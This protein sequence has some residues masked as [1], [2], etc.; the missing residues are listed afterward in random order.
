MIRELV[1]LEMLRRWSAQASTLEE[2]RTGDFILEEPED[3]ERVRTS[4]RLDKWREI[5]AKGDAEDFRQNLVWAGLSE[6]EALRLLGRVKLREAAPLPTW[7]E[8]LPRLLD[9]I[10]SGNK[11]SVSEFTLREPFVHLFL[12]L[13]QAL[14]ERIAKDWDTSRWNYSVCED[15]SNGLL[16]RIVPPFSYS[17]YSWFK[18]FRT[19]KKPYIQEAKI[20]SSNE[21]TSLIYDAYIEWLRSGHLIR[22]L[23]KHPVLARLLVIVTE[24]WE[25]FISEFINHLETDLPTLVALFF[26]CR[27]PGQVVKLEMNISE[28]HNRGR[29]VVI[30][31]FSSGDRLVYK[32]RD[33]TIDQRWNELTSWMK[34][35]NAPYDL[36][37]AKVWGAEGYGWVEYVDSV[38]CHNEGEVRAF[39]HR[40]GALLSLFHVLGGTDF[41]QENIV[42]HSCYPIPIDLETLL[43]PK[44]DLSSDSEAHPAL[45]EAQ[46][47][48]SR[49]VLASGYLP[50][51]NEFRGNTWASGG[52]SQLES[53]ATTVAG[54]EYVNTD[55]MCL[56]RVPLPPPS[57]KHLPHLEGVLVNSGD[58]SFE[59]ESG[60]RQTCQ[61]LMAHR[62]ILIRE[63]LPTFANTV[64]RIVRQETRLYQLLHK[65]ALQPAMLADGI[66]FSLEFE[67]LSRLHDRL[68]TATLAQVRAE[69]H[70][71][72]HLD[73][74]SFRMYAN[75][76]IVTEA[77]GGGF[78]LARDGKAVLSPVEHALTRLKALDEA[79]IEQQ[80]ELIRFAL[81]K[82]RQKVSKAARWSEPSLST[83]SS[84]AAITRA[85]ELGEWI[86][87]RAIMRADGAAWLGAVA[88]GIEERIK[89]MPIGFDLYSGA[90]GIAIFLGALY[91]ITGRELFRDF[92]LKAFVPLRYDL[93]RDAR[94]RS[95]ARTIG[96]G[97]AIGMGSIVYALV[98]TALL[99]ELPQL[100]DDA[101][102]AAKLFTDSVIASDSLFDVVSGAAGAILGLLAL[103]DAT[104]DVIALEKATACGWHLLRHHRPKTVGEGESKL[105]LAGF[106]HGA[107][108][109]AYAL[110]RLADASKV[111]DFLTA[112]MEW[113]AYEREL[114]DSNAGNWLDLRFQT[115][116]SPR[117][118][119]FVCN[120]CHGAAGIGLGRLGSYG[121]GRD[122]DMPAEID[123]A[124]ARA[125]AEPLG[126]YDILC[127]GNFGR[128]ELLL[129][130]GYQ[131]ERPHLIDLA[132]ERAALRLRQTSCGFDWFIGTDAENIGFFQGLAGIGYEL[133]RL[134]DPKKIPSTLLWQV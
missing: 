56:G 113:L 97:G 116:E 61:F 60:F 68:D 31:H 128:L 118:E 106:S 18:H 62:E 44:V 16:S 100:L 21:P 10:G 102:Q 32:P 8:N 130:V 9:L 87:E 25:K 133:L 72:Y 30:L 92:C 84:S 19:V 58:Y 117:P 71:M 79:D 5:V 51:W 74:P 75:S 80:C 23:E 131:L 42:A 35:A 98:L 34:L 104:G 124:V 67:F 54:F 33:L 95:L 12:P 26:D 107:A 109:I 1:S 127:C 7:A 40:A 15:L 50:C 48:I 2:R 110:Q 94:A 29:G 45:V 55:A 53:T 69:C 24:Q 103:H 27:D 66:D 123:L 89:L 59:I 65:R 99:A 57:T 46:Q 88:V 63:R 129:S 11:S 85:V 81:G 114:F 70:A 14:S 125:L 49:S 47:S 78:D 83:W 82:N 13:S 121:T 115:K 28:P 17:L 37:S 108:G 122:R 86:V 96:I 119:Y 36:R 134:S 111:T 64:I 112:V 43:R 41:H 105:L 4:R 132:R 38:P 91:R 73:I 77:S 101:R 20:E 76:T 3:G 126:S 90:G 52:L 39:F 120:W 6:S 22:L 93:A